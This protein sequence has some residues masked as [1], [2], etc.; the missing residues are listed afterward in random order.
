[1]EEDKLELAQEVVNRL[2]TEDDPALEAS[3][4]RMQFLRLQAEEE[5]E[6][7]SRRE[8]REIALFETRNEALSK[9][10]EARSAREKEQADESVESLLQCASISNGFDL[11]DVKVR[12]EATAA[13][14][15]VLPHHLLVKFHEQS[16]TEKK[17]QVQELE[18]LIQGIRI[19]N[20]H[21]GTGGYG[22]ED[23]SHV[24]LR[25]PFVLDVVFS[26]FL[27]F[28]NGVA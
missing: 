18:S 12:Q 14:Q 7:N 15:S 16:K 23:L 13:L 27:G 26:L 11:S 8:K 20:H 10:V 4:L 21:R 5:E 2:Q 6:E 25:F 3:K 1:M 17:Q 9:K 22:L 28:G 19:F 24:R